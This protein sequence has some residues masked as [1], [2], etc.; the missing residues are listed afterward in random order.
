MNV[1]DIRNILDSKEDTTIFIRMHNITGGSFAN[2]YE[3][4]NMLSETNKSIIILC[5]GTI[6]LTGIIPLLS[7]YD[8]KV[9]A[10]RDTKF[11]IDAPEYRKIFVESVYKDEFNEIFEN[12]LSVY[13]SFSVI[14]ILF[15]L[16]FKKIFTPEEFIVLG[17]LD[18][19]CE[20]RYTGTSENE[21]LNGLLKRAEL[22][23]KRRRRYELKNI[24]K[25]EIIP[26]SEN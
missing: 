4:G 11:I 6:N 20:N 13:A 1:S 3:L 23:N 18:D 8:I 10:L 21:I 24:G 7:N 26:Y 25:L 2:A 22:A 17:I 16:K 12:L 9:S 5:S 19:I 14:E 15:L